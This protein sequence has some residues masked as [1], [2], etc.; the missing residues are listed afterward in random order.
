MDDLGIIIGG[1]LLTVAGFF[2]MKK[3]A[4][5]QQTAS[6]VASGAVLGGAAGAAAKTVL[7]QTRTLTAE[8]LAPVIAD[9]NR[10]YFGGWFKVADVL[11]IIYVESSFRPWVYRDEPHINDRSIGLMQ[12]LKSTAADRGYIGT[13]SGL[14]DPETNIRLGMAHLKWGYDYLAKRL[15][16]APVEREWITA[17]NAGVGNVLKGYTNDYY[18]KFANARKSYI[19]R[20]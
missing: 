6:A 15:G 12:L 4:V 19:G 16:R 5:P 2:G 3:A 1:F 8:E 14:Y 20:F 13:E 10:R 9:F 18:N 11:A 17:Y 7:P